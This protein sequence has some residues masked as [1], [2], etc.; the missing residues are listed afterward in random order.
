MF[1]HSGDGKKSVLA[2]LGC[3]EK[4]FGVVGIARKVCNHSGDGMKIVLG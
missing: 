2:L 4:C 1:G 3:Q